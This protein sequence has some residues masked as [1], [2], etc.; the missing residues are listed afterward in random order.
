MTNKIFVLSLLVLL[1]T[2]CDKIKSTEKKMDGEWTVYKL[3]VTQSNGLSQHYESVGT[4]RFYDFEDGEGSYDLNI[5]YQAN[6]GLVTKNETGKIVLKE[7]G[8][9]YD[10]FKNNPN[11]SITQIQNGRILL[12]TKNDIETLYQDNNENFTMVLEK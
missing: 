8:E 4:F 10:L 11:G 12:I 5:A 3:K 9:Y 2:A 6:A 7:K 1:F